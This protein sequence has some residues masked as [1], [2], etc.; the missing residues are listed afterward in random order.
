MESLDE[1]KEK[2]YYTEDRQY[3]LLWRKAALHLL[4]IETV[5]SQ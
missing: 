5:L 3:I 4:L 1:G 2:E